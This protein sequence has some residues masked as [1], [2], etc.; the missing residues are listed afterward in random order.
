MTLNYFNLAHFFFLSMHLYFG[1]C[2]NNNNN[3]NN[4]MVSG[5]PTVSRSEGTV[6]FPKRRGVSN[7]V[8]GA[9]RAHFQFFF[10]RALK[11]LASLAVRR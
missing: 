4:S 8:P 2:N 1:V 9:A 7:C 6:S 3:N 10:V 11:Q 5:P